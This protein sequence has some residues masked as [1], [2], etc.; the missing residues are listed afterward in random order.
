MDRRWVCLALLLLPLA[1]AA[2]EERPPLSEKLNTGQR[3]YAEYQRYCAVCHGIFADGN[4]FAAPVLT[5][6][7]TNL[8]ILHARFGRPLSRPALT[9]KI[10]GS[11]PILAHGTREMPIWGERLYEDVPTRMPDARSRGAILVIIEYLDSI[12]DPPAD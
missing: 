4:G 1:A 11:E 9:R 2:Q 12:Q 3:G 8:R 6:R 10:D 7:P 5:V